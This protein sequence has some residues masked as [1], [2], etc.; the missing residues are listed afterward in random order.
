L[1]FLDVG[2][3]GFD[4]RPAGALLAAAE[5]DFFDYSLS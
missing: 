1:D 3:V 2:A 4:G 5:L